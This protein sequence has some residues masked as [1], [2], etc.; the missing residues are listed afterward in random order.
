M[1]GSASVDVV[2]RLFRS[3]TPF[4]DPLPMPPRRV[5]TEPTRLHVHVRAA[6]HQFHSEMPPSRVWTYDGHL[7]GPT[8]EVR[9]GVAVEVQWDN[10]LDGALPVTVV[11]APSFEVDGVPVQCVP[12]RSG[13]LPDTDAAALLGYSVVHL[14]GGLTP[15][16]S[17]GWTE[18]LARPGQSALDVYPNDQ[19]AAMLWYHDHVM[20]VTRFSVYAGL[21]GIWI[22]RDERER[23]LDLPE[24]P[25]FEVP[26][27]FTDRNFDVAPDGRL[28]GELL[29]KTDPEV[30][31]CF[32][33]FTAVNG[34]IW[35]VVEVQPTTYRFRLL[36]G[37]N[38]RTYRLVLTRAGRVLPQY[39]QNL[40]PQGLVLASAERADLL[41]DFS[42]LAPGVELTLWNTAAAPFDGTFA[43]PAVAGAG[44]A[45][46]DGLLLFR[47]CSESVL[48]RA[49]GRAVRY[50][51]CWRPTSGR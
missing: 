32:S 44:A 27:L 45:S 49:T 33:P 11:R 17:D 46:L 19:R 4:V 8:I 29:H 28:T 37:S 5:I 41:V 38:A 9:R 14:H 21:A 1:T 35:P 50:A 31:E 16:T 48:S 10:R 51:P 47:K 23:E 22:V 36:N 20:G 6:T 7:P 30:M 12:G 15:A 18:N 25:P 13:G 2:S 24:G 42:D 40:P 39:T 26:L 3:L 43:D 34:A